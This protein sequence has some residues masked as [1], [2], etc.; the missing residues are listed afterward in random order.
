MLDKFS[1]IELGFQELFH[2]FAGIKANYHHFVLPVTLSKLLVLR[3][4]QRMDEM[5]SGF[6]INN[7]SI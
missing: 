5:N 3:N 1:G 6:S 2:L 7:A 4:P